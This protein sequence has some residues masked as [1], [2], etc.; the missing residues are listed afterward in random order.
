MYRES[1]ED[2]MALRITKYIVSLKRK[3]QDGESYL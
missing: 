1:L 3:N 2:V